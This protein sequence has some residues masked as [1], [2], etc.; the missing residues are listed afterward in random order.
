MPAKIFKAWRSYA[1]SRNRTF[2]GFTIR[3]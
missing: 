2:Q 3:L 1:A